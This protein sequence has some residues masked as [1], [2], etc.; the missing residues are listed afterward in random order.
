MP[1]PEA[2]IARWG[3]LIGVLR[4]ARRSAFLAMFLLSAFVVA[5]PARAQDRTV[6]PPSPIAPFARNCLDVTTFGAN[7]TAGD[8]ARIGK[9]LLAA[10]GAGGGCV[11]APAIGRPYRIDSGIAIPAGVALYG[12]GARYF[13]GLDASLRTW[14]AAG[15]WFQCVDTRRPCIAIESHG[16]TLRGIN[17][18]WDQVAP[19]AAPYRPRVYP[20]G[21]RI[22]GTLFEVSDIMMVGGTHCIEVDYTPGSGG[23]TYSRLRDLKLGCLDRGIRLSNVNDNVYLSDVDVRPLWHQTNAAQVEYT[24]RHLVGMDISYWDNPIIASYH[25]FHCATALKLSDGSV[26]GNRHGLFNGQLD[27][28]QCN[29]VRVCILADEGSVNSFSVGNLLAQ[30]SDGL[31]DTLF[32]L[33]ADGLDV[34]VANLNLVTAGGQAFA[35]GGGSGGTLAIANL[36]IGSDVDGRVV[37]GYSAVVPG[38]VAFGVARGF[39]LSIGTRRVL[40][41]AGAGAYI[42]GAGANDVQG[43]ETCRRLRGADRGIGQRSGNV[44]ALLQ[45]RLTGR[46]TVTAPR[47][48]ATARIALA[49]FPAAGATV[50]LDGRGAREFDTNWVDVRGNGSDPGDIQQG[51]TAGAA[52]ALSELIVCGR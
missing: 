31:S 19:Q 47:P 42:A 7:G 23:G 36:K 4:I 37:G 33:G 2:S 17:L 22:S 50:P 40:R 6:S 20:Y 5:V 30:Q 41:T 49:E 9:A 18:I 26:L 52:Y 12:A 28:I 21:L 10:A 11:Y 8:G 51:S 1:A 25:C 44:G 29:L 27:N 48:G 13:D 39:R 14:S 15:T 38:K 35:L 3:G 24:L 43:P 16:S 32:Q 34:S 45:V 46:L